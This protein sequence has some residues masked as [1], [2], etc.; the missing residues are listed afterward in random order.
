[1]LTHPT[2]EALQT[3][4]LTGMVKAF[5]EQL[6]MAEIDSLSFEQRLGLLVE[7]EATERANRRLARRLKQAKLRQAAAIED[8][9]FRAP[10][11]LDKKLILSLG[12]CDWIAQH[13]NVLITGPTGVGKTFLACA[14]AH[15]ACREGHS[16]LYLRMPR[17]FG[18]LA[19]AKGDGR[20]PKLMQKFARTHL[21]VFDDWGLTPLDDAARRDLLEILED[22]CEL[23]STLVTSQLPLDQWHQAIGDPTLADAILDR[24][25]H[26]A[27]PIALK[28][29]SMRRRR[30]RRSAPP[31]ET[32]S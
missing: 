32:K 16:A 14:L 22:R 17:L 28:G 3:L 26:R 12:A 5:E 10:R 15:K 2:L 6:Q 11:G 31:Q 7:R 21:L 20:Y 1:M 24:L 29:D 19:I 30:A 13:K 18:D 9:D 25:V 27:Y 23:R 8:L 4:R